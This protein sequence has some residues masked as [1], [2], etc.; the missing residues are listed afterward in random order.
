MP[1]SERV[2]LIRETRETLQQMVVEAKLW[3]SLIEFKNFTINEKILSEEM[4]H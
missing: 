2:K 4:N 3:H 1:N